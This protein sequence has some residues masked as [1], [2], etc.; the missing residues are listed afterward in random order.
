MDGKN[1]SASYGLKKHVRY[2]MVETG[3]Q[4]DEA[5]IR[6]TRI[7][8]RQ[9]P[10]M[11]AGVRCD[12]PLGHGGVHSARDEDGRLRGRRWRDAMSAPAPEKGT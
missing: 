8:N 5:R 2:E 11:S 4:I 1:G 12:Q 6:E 7:V 3:R 9:C 10:S